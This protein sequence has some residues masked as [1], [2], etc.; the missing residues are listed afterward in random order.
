MKRPLVVIAIAIAV[1][2]AIAGVA[3]ISISNSIVASEE[4]VNASW[5]EV[6][7]QLQRRFD[8]IPNLVETVKGYAAHEKE[9]FAAIAEAR[10]KLAG[11]QTVPQK[12]EASNALEGALSRLLMVVEN[13]PQLKADASFRELMYELS[14]TENRIAV[15]RQRYNET[16]RAFNVKIRI[17]PNSIVAGMRGITPRELFEAQSGAESAPKVR[18]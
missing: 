6:E 7:N 2:A 14:G 18:F 12:I 3:F 4:A 15:A 17:F 16:V 13:Y 9:V 5:S 8:L 1:L 10:S 11:A